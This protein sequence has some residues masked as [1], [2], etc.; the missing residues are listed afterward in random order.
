MLLAAGADARA[1]D[2]QHRTVLMRLTDA[3]CCR[4]LLEAGARADARDI[5]GRGV[6]RNIA[7]WAK[8]RQEF[9]WLQSKI[10]ARYDRNLAET[11]RLLIAAGAEL[12]PPPKPG[13]TALELLAKLRVPEAKQVLSS[14]P[15]RTT[16]K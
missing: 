12:E 5:S 6:L 11:F 13:D 10:D 9:S 8:R 2:D 3:E 4:M 1:V 16:K 14:A 7:W 15:V